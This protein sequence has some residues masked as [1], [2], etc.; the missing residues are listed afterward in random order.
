M[1]ELDV[2]AVVV[3]VV[4]VEEVVAIEEGDKRACSGGGVSA[5]LA[6]ICPSKT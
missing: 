6:A 1:E 5:F 2:L 4:A 3:G